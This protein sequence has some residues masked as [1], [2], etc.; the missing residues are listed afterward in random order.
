MIST[1]HLPYPGLRRQNLL[2]L[3]SSGLL[4]VAFLYGTGSGGVAISPGAVAAILA[5]QVGIQ[6]PWSFTAQE[7]AVLLAIRLPRVCLGALVGA[8]LAISGGAL[9]GLFRNPLADPGLIGVSTGSALA[10]ACVIVLGSGVANMLPAFQTALL[11]PLAAFLGGLLATLLVYAIA[12]RDGQT[13]VAIMLLAGVALNAI[14][15]AG[16]GLL[17]FVSSDAQL[18]DLNFW[19]LGSLSGVTWARLLPVIPFLTVPLLL[20]LTQARTLNALL[21]GETEAQHLGFDTQR[22]KQIIIVL[23]ALA[24]GS[25]VALT[26]VIG[27]VGLVVP[28]LIRLLAG[29]DHRSLL[30]ASML[31]GA[32]L[33]LI[34][35]L[36]ARILV[37]PAELPVGILTS[38]VGGP[39]FLWLLLTHRSRRQW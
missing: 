28:H 23:A 8:A 39:F 37:L 1:P 19:L 34:A 29:P 35:D 13:D 25:S 30:P 16:I 17:V 36:A 7:Q 18:R 5:S 12:S 33:M 38:C 20:L 22:S 24:I 2:L 15:G 21:L 11:L 31:L 14:A 4:L 6:L 9:Q 10:A 27:F 32:S 26:G 3:T